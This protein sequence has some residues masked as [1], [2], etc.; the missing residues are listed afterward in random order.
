MDDDAF[1]ALLCFRL[2]S[3]PKGSKLHFCPSGCN[4]KPVDQRDWMAHV[5]GCAN[6]RGQNAS[7]RHKLLKDFM[8]DHVYAAA[9]VSCFGYEPR[10]KTG[11]CPGIGCGIK[12][13][14]DL[15]EAHCA[16]CPLIPLH[17]RGKVKP[18][19]SGPDD[20]I[21]L[22]I[23]KVVVDYTIVSTTSISNALK[24][25][26]K[27]A[28]AY[29]NV[30]NAK[31]GKYAEPVALDNGQ[32]VVLAASAV[33]HLAPEFRALLQE[34]AKTRRGLS[35]EQY[36]LAASQCVVQCGGMVLLNAMHRAGVRAL[37]PCRVGRRT[38]KRVRSTIPKWYGP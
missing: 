11:K 31:M 16:E 24:A 17:L 9:G 15:V 19:R 33:G 23:G 7:H 26:R 36:S 29:S 3:Y 38:C 10:Y 18:F 30:V 27:G 13:P 35:F 28:S 32:L 1:G 34:I 25:A 12:G 20:T 21:L 14:I 22:R 5:L 8:R 37:V 2:Y 6:I 4:Y